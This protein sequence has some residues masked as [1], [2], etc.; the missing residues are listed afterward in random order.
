MNPNGGG[1]VIVTLQKPITDT[2][3]SELGERT[4]V[5]LYTHNNISFGKGFIISRQYY[6]K[7]IEG[8]DLDDEPE[9]KPDDDNEPVTTATIR[10]GHVD[11]A[12][13]A[14]AAFKTKSREL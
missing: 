13:Q 2:K 4:F 8:K 11:K 6:F 3:T 7:P 9:S 1:G 5:N 10:Q 12:R 14:G